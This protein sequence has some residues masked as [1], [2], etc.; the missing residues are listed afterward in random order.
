MKNFCSV[1][2]TDH[3]RTI[4][5]SIL[6]SKLLAPPRQI[7]HPLTIKGMGWGGG[8]GGKVAAVSRPGYATAKSN[9]NFLAQCWHIFRSAGTVC[10]SQ[11]QAVLFIPVLFSFFIKVWN[12]IS[13]RWKVETIGDAYLC[14]SGVPRR[15]GTEHG[16]EIA[17]M[18]MHLL[19]S[20]KNFRVAHLPDVTLQV[21]IGM[22]TGNSSITET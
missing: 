12:L 16:R 22:H 15:N 4:E 10:F 9:A 14:V 6:L 20:I 3:L 8:G 17:N 21:R 2:C 7:W 11:R 5:S 18:S 1:T 19:S 13:N